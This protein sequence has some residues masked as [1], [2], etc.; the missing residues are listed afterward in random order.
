MKRPGIKW[1]LAVTTLVLM[2]AGTA[3][4][5]IADTKHNLSSQGNFAV[6]TTSD[7]GICIFCHTP[8]RARTDVGLLW[9]RP[10]SAVAEYQTYESSSMLAIVGQPT[11]ASKL[12]LSCHDG[13]IAL[14]S[15][16]S[17]P[18][19]LEF[20]D[21]IRFIPDT[22]SR[23]GSDLRDD[24]PVSFLYD[25][26][27][28]ADNGELVLPATLTEEVDLDKLDNVQCTSCHDPHDDTLGNFLVR[29][30]NFSELCVTCHNRAGWTASSHSTSLATWDGSETDPWLHAEFSNVAENACASCHRSHNGEGIPGLLNYAIEEDNCLFCHN[31]NVAD[32]DI[33]DELS[34]KAYSHPVANFLGDHEAGEDF[35]SFSID[36]HVECADCHNPHRVNDLEQPTPQVSGTQLGVTGISS[37]G[38]HVDE[39][40]FAYEICYKCHADN[41]VISVIDITRQVPQINT[42][43]E[44][45][46]SNPS[47]HPVEAAGKNLGHVPS[48]ILPLT[49]TS[50]ILCTDCH[51]N[52]EGTANGGTGPDGPHASDYQYLLERNYTTADNT[53]ESAFEYAL[54]Y[55]CHD[56]ISILGDESFEHEEHLGTDVNAPCSACHDPHGVGSP[57]SAL[58]NSHLINFDT[59]IVTDNGG[60]LEFI[61]GSLPFTGSCA[62]S[63]HGEDHTHADHD[64]EP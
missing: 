48:L 62:L 12:C 10:D 23:I 61:N 36:D 54:C 34:T 63:C 44:F 32:T 8:H 16:L 19:E 51:G 22:D 1:C 24:H 35:T 28:A 56:Q 49:E 5:Q 55:K 47:Y 21:D 60:L 33:E 53:T 6:K 43:H 46:P 39:A 15:I 14:G 3:Q 58:N 37:A 18:T 52:N 26:D 25:G 31:G 4:A 57:G 41:N 59:N 64:Y 42:R 45:D 50:Q 20:E 2:L 17:S 29:R 7:A 30:Q 13:T 38:L 9:N 27:L 11:G 40:D